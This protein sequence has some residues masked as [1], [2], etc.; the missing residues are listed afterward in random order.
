MQGPR[1][2]KGLTRLSLDDFR[3]GKGFDRNP[4]TVGVFLATLP[5]RTRRRGGVWCLLPAGVSPT[6]YPLSTRTG[7]GECLPCI[8]LRILE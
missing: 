7:R 1:S 6:H 2:N 3:K 8:S 5:E 4:E